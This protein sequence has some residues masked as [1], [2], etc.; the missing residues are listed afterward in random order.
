MPVRLLLV[1]LGLLAAAPLV[2]AFLYDDGGVGLWSVPFIILL[3][4]GFVFK[5][6]LDWAYYTRYPVDLDGRITELLDV[7]QPRWYSQLSAPDRLALRQ[8]TALTLMGLDFKPQG[9]GDDA[10]PADVEAL[11]AAQVARI[12]IGLSP[13][14]IIPAPFENVVVYKHPFPSPQYPRVFH[15]SELFAE[16]GVIMLSLHQA[17]PATLDPQEYFNIALYE[18]ARA[19]E[20]FLH[21]A[22]AARPPTPTTAEMLDAALGRPGSW[23][24]DAIGLPVVDDLAVAQ[25]LRLDF[26]E[27]FAKTYPALGTELASRFTG[28]RRSTEPT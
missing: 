19:F 4:L 11:L 26:P 28:G 27:A 25:V 14:L 21:G 17:L 16:D 9:L 2:Y 12:S 13:K 7:K 24:V 18:W 8:R 6:E 1:A 20:L 22:T 23:V 3:A 5:P 10:L 15:A